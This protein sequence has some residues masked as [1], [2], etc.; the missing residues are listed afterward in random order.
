MINK[1]IAT[2]NDKTLSSSE[3]ATSTSVIKLENVKNGS[4]FQL[5]YEP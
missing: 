3:S 4:L 2:S 1:R 5:Q